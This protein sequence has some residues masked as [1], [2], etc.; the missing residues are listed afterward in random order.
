MSSVF[1]VL[2]KDVEAMKE[3][4]QDSV[5]SFNGLVFNRKGVKFS[6]LAGDPLP[7][8]CK[9][10]VWNDGV[11]TVAS[12]LYN[13]QDTGT[14]KSLHTDL[15]GT[16][17]FSNFVKPRLAIGPKGN[18]MPAPPQGP[19]GFGLMDGAGDILSGGR[20]YGASGPEDNE[21]YASAPETP[22]A[23]SAK[24]APGQSVVIDIPVTAAA[25]LG[26]TFMA[27]PKVSAEL[28]D[29]AGTRAGENPADAPAAR[30]WFR[31]IFFDRPTASGTWKLKLTNTGQF[32]YEAVVTAWQA[33]A[34][35]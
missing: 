1:G 26:V 20:V 11:V 15:T 6:A 34:R 12:A 4:T 35:N 17:D 25:N 22:F 23:R 8:T 9:E 31:S 16:S 28:I 32:E 10:I 30:A 33:G 3:L 5:R 24:I 13:V 14:S 2:G 21:I 29:A 27:D 7:N 19:S 18:H